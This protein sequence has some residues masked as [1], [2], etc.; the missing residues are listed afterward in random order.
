M[1]CAL[2]TRFGMPA[3]KNEL[4][5]KVN[6]DSQD[7]D[8]TNQW[9][10]V[11]DSLEV[12]DALETALNNVTNPELLQNIV[13]VTSDLISHIDREFALQIANN[14]VTWPATRFFTRII[15]RL[16]E[17]EPVLHVL[18]PNYDTL[19]EHACD[20]VGIPYTSGFVGGLERHLDWRATEHSL[21]QRQ[22][23]HRRAR[24][25]WIHKYT[26]HIRIYKAHGSLN[27]FLHQNKFVENN[28][29]M[30]DA[31]DFSKR[32]MI[33]PGL[34]KYEMLQRYR[35]ELLNPVDDAIKRAN[36]FLFLGYGFND[37]HLE[38]HIIPKLTTQACNGLILTRSSNP[39]IES[40]LSQAQ[41]LWLV[42]K[43]Q[44]GGVDGTRISNNQHPSCLFL[45][46]ERLWDIETFTTEILGA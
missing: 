40:L 13:A 39:R 4:L 16:P 19:F 17:G 37:T 29:W 11:A 43:S 7:S 22:R 45:P 42:C 14:E 44:Q 35:Q 32:V 9:R 2:D 18:T 38:T 25:K 33:T 21:L 26:K 10:R 20:S 24:L 27:F 12:G 31:P 41:N 1:S 5:R 30:W 36:R 23:V 3:L 8:Q 6:P 28:A 34:S 15:D 46:E